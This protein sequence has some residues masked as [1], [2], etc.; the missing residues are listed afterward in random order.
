MS[1]TNSFIDEVND[2]VRRDKFYAAL[3]RYGWIAALL[4]VLIVGAAAW[5]EYRKSQARAQAEAV[6][7][8][9]LAALAGPDAAGRLSALDSV[10]ASAPGTQAVTAF[11]RAAQAEETGDLAAAVAALD[12]VAVDGALPEIYRQLAAFKSLSLQI[13]TMPENELRQ[14]FEVLGAT[15]AAFSLLARE[16]IALLDV[17]AGNTEAALAGYQAILS[18]AAVT[19]DLQQ[20]ALQVIV[21]LG[22]A[23][24]LDNQTGVE[25]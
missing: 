11:L 14:G 18:D 22:G 8:A 13:P 5:N 19:P 20:R 6:G 10:P 12:A 23:P 7:D 1:D 4:V 24:E 17:R 2:E 25:N 9:L 21:A 15:G 3:R 16:Q